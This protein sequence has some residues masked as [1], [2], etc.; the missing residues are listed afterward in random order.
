MDRLRV[1]PPYGK[2]FLHTV[3]R[4][5]VVIGRSTAVDIHVPDRFLSRQHA[6]LFLKDES[7]WIEDL[8]S[9]NGSWINGKRIDCPIVFGQDD[10]VRLS[11]THLYF[12]PGAEEPEPTPTDFITSESDVAFRPVDELI[13]SAHSLGPSELDPTETVIRQSE[14]LR[15][16]NQFHSSLSQPL[17]LDNLLELILDQLF[18]ALR[19]DQGIIYLKQADGLNQRAAERSIG[20]LT[21]EHLESHTLLTKVADEGLTALVNGL[22]TPSDWQSGD[23]I[24]EQ[25]VKSLTAAPLTDSQGT[26]GMIAMSSNRAEVSFGEQEQELL[27]S[28]ASVAA[29]R[30]RNMLLIEEAAREAAEIER[31]DEE[32][33]LARK[34]QVGLLPSK[35]PRLEGFELRGSSIPCRRVSGDFYQ[36]IPRDDGKEVVVLVADVVGKGLGASLV[37]ASLE[38]LAIGP[39]EAGHPPAEICRR[40]DRR[41]YART[42]SG[43]FSAMFIVL[44]RAEEDRVSFANAGLNP[45]LLVRSSGRVHQ[46]H[47]SGPPLGLLLGATYKE[48][49]RRLKDG[50]LLVLYTDGLTE[51]V[52]PTDQEYGLRRLINVCRSQRENSLDEIAE[53]IE[54]DLEEFVHGV[55]YD[56]DRTLVLARRI[57]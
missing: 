7:W 29:L 40:L 1:V 42:T 17:D 34:I 14:H 27:V 4:R 9:R 13:K 25:G 12:S 21:T 6:R 32:L 50:D 38:A 56:D 26:L 11:N 53:A 49:T 8:A 44:L 22:N 2:S 18:D 5:P 20:G 3:K 28:L 57:H 39:I 24:L 46:L 19:A 35:T 33:L 10:R 45:G 15:L 54:I 55:P 16:L 52:N 48:S 51:A 37:T 41:L 30:I 23:S 47:A 31:L 36:M 43:K